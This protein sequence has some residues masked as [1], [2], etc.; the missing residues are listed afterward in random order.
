M[1]L[2]NGQEIGEQL[3][4]NGEYKRVNW[5]QK[6]SEMLIKIIEETW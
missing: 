4:Y 5:K 1:E 3:K 2:L 6:E